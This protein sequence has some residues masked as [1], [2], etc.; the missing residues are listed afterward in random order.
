M[1]REGELDI[2]SVEQWFVLS[3]VLLMVEALRHQ[4]L[5]NGSIWCVA[6]AIITIIL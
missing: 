5:I 1:S 6:H 2:L 3:E 4:W